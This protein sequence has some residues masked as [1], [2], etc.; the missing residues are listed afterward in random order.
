MD[1]VDA[2]SRCV[3]VNIVYSRVP[4]GG[5]RRFCLRTAFVL[6]R[7]HVVGA[8]VQLRHQVPWQGTKPAA[9]IYIVSST[10]SFILFVNFRGF[11]QNMEDEM[12]WRRSRSSMAIT[13]ACVPGDSPQRQCWDRDISNRCKGQMN[14]CFLML[15]LL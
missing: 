12:S 9:A 15:F 11:P 6:T 3:D 2:L 13:C 14:P 10:L 5:T 4:C 1:V 8:R 7:P